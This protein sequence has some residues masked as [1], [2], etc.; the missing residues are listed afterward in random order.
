MK[1]E[2]WSDFS[3]PF[4]Y[5]GKRRLE[6]AL[7]TFPHA[8]DV[9]IEYRSY[10]LD[11]NS[12][13]N[14]PLNGYENFAKKHHMTLEQAKQRVAMF[15]QNAATVGLK[16]N[17]DILKPTNTFDAHRLAKWANTQGLETKLTERLMQAYFSE[18]LNIGNHETLA[19]LAGEVGLDPTAAKTILDSDDFGDQVR[20]EIAE[21]SEIGVQGVPFFVINRKYAI[22][23]AQPLEYFQKALEQI[24][25]ED[26]PKINV[27]DDAD[28]EGHVCTDEGCE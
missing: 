12:D 2:L 22:S 17:Y 20:N 14:N 28:E 10:Q 9:T 27:F 7:A 4:C 23:G 6:M 3:C 19:K 13:A 21:G 18:G 26:Q 11:P 8:K 15:N 16:Y 25:Q 5:V 1:I 24:W